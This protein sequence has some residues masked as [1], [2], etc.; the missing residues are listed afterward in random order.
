MKEMIT[1]IKNNNLDRIKELISTRV[2]ING[3]LKVRGEEVSNYFWKEDKIFEI[4]PLY[5]A[6][7]LGQ[8]EIVSLLLQNGADINKSDNND[9]WTPLYS[10]ADKGHLE[11]VKLLIENDA[12]INKSVGQDLVK[13]ALSKKISFVSKVTDESIPPITPAIASAF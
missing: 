3:T 5:Y 10:A 12:D 11:V 1:A 13:K 8:T 7:T 9:E 6:A 4:T 2:D